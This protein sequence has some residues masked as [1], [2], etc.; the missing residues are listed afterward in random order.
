MSWCASSSKRK[1]TGDAAPTAA[2]LERELERVLKK[3]RRRLEKHRR[4]IG[5]L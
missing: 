3:I 4:E 2:D 1:A 5:P